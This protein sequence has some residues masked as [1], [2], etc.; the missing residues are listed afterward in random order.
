[1][2]EALDAALVFR[3][4]GNDES[5]PTDGDDAVL[6]ILLL[7]AGKIP[8][9]TGA[10]AL[11]QLSDLRTQRKELFARM[12]GELVLV[13]DLAPDVL[14]QVAIEHEMLGESAHFYDAFIRKRAHGRIEHA[15][16]TQKARNTEKLRHG[17]RRPLART[18]ETVF[19]VGE[20]LHLALAER[21]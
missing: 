16:R 6:Q 15:R 17:E 18:G 19:A 21:K 11:A 12:V 10:D 9:Q 7:L 14:L 4:D 8:L 5:I 3:L 20:F 2:H 13:Q 1:M